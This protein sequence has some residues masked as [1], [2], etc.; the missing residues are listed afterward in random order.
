[1]ALK[2]L[3]DNLKSLAWVLWL[4]I[5][6]FV[7]LVFFEWGGVNRAPN[8]RTDVAATVG[9]GRITW[10]DLQQQYQT[11]ERQYREALGESF[12]REMA[13]RFNLPAQ[14]LNQLIQQEILLQE[15]ARAGLE[16]TD[17]EVQRAILQIP[18]LTDESGRFV[19]KEDYLR[20]LRRNRID[21]V[22][23]EASVRNDVLLQKLRSVLGASI[24]VTSEEVERA[25]REQTE[26]ADVRYVELPAS[27]FAGEVEASP[28]RL[29]EYFAEHSAEYRLPEQRVIDYLLVS[30]S[31]LRQELEVGE[32][33]LRAYYEE[34]PDEF[35][36]EEEVRA[37]HVLLKVGPDEDAAEVEAELE[38]IRRRIESGEDFAA[39]ARELSEDPGSAARGGDLGFFGRGRM[40]QEFEEAAFGA[41]VG[42]LVGPIRTDFGFHLIEVRDRRP[43]GTIPF[44]EAGPRIR[45]RLLQERVDGMAEAKARDLADRIAAGGDEASG[46]ATLEELAAEEGLEIRTS[47]PF[48]ADATVPGLGRSPRLLESAFSLGAGEISEA[49]EVPTGW[50]VFRVAEV[51]P[52]RDP[53]LE[54]VEAQVRRDL[55]GDLRREAARQRLAE[56][57][58]TAGLEQIAAELEVEVQEAA[59]LGRRGSI[60]STGVD[61]EALDAAFESPVGQVAGPFS[62]REGAMLLVVTDRTTFDPAAFAEE[63]EA[64][65]EQQEAQRLEQLLASIVE[66]RRRDLAPNYD[67]RVFEQFDIEPPSVG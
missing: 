27:R 5:G 51:L 49:L 57:S 59:D 17:E 23:F 25:Y 41:E 14:A 10:A 65:R 24:W 18:G 53:E 13:K 50:V 21:K 3:R 52:P 66:I 19:G 37:R 34:H 7:L 20:I 11:L 38:A 4:V 61:P 62:T 48:A 56:L 6:V 30:D 12:D 2:W 43:G 26:K 42:D 29:A 33:E 35:S 47:P 22:D 44:D 15:A 39:L 28:E 1:M 67:P 31:R 60:G 9:D 8:P 36:R 58:G 63:R 46:G 45:S 54:D 55:E 64:V 40:I 32:E 16:A